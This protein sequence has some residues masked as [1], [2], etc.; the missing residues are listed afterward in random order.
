MKK[1]TL[2]YASIIQVKYLLII[3]VVFYFVTYICYNTEDVLKGTFRDFLNIT[4][5]KRESLIS[6]KRDYMRDFM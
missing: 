6:N 3:N 5:T 1:K 2:Q 4:L